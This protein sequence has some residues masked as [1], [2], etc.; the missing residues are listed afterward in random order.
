MA[1][2]QRREQ[3]NAI[4]NSLYLSIA[5]SVRIEN[6]GKIFGFCS[7]MKRSEKKVYFFSKKIW[8]RKSE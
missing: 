1:R 7:R 6:E 8:L 3:K 2:F 4:K 5:Y